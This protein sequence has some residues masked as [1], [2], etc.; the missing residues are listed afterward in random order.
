MGGRLAM[1]TTKRLCALALCAL[2]LAVGAAMAA[3]SADTHAQC[4]LIRPSGYEGRD[5][6]YVWESKVYDL[7]ELGSLL[8]H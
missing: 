6:V 4:V 2:T 3:P 1:K 8:S 7:D 5:D